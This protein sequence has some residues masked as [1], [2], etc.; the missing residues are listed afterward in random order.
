MANV[1]IETSRAVIAVTRRKQVSQAAW[2][3]ARW[4]VRILLLA[5]IGTI[6]ADLFGIIFNPIILAIAYLALGLGIYLL[7]IDMYLRYRWAGLPD[8]PPLP[9]MLA[10]QPPPNLADYLSEEAADYLL[11]ARVLSGRW[12][13]GHVTAAA[14]FAAAISFPRTGI[15]LQ[16]AG[17][18]L[19]DEQEAELI[20]RLS[21][22]NSAESAQ[23]VTR[24]FELAAESVLTSQ[25][26]RIDEG[27]LLV[28]IFALEPA[29]Q[30]VLFEYHSKQEDLAAVV[31]WMR[32]LRVRYAPRPGYEQPVASGI[33]ED[34][35][36]GY[37]PF[38]S[39]FAS[40][41]TAKAERLGR[42]FSLYSHQDELAQIER[43]LAKG[44]GSNALIIGPPGVGKEAIIL[45]LA[46]RI[47][48]GTSLPSLQFARIL[49]VDPASLLAGAHDKG[50]LEARLLRVFHEAAQAGNVILYLDNIHQLTGGGERLGGVDATELL[51][52]ALQAST[53]RIIATTIPEEYKARI[54]ANPTLASL[55][56]HFNIDEPSPAAT[57]QVLQDIV[58]ETEEATGAF[59]TYPALRAIV[60]VADR[61]LHDQ[62][63]PQK[64]INLLTDIGAYA[65]STQDRLITAETVERVLAE[66]LQLPL[67]AAQGTERE[68]LLNLESEL[69]KTVIAQDEAIGA[70]AAALRRARAGIQ[71]RK[72]PIASLLF[73]GPTGVGK[74]ESAK[75]LARVYF[76]SEQ[77]MLRFD[78]SE[79]QLVDGLV[80]LI[81]APA[82]AQGVKVGGLLADAVH[83]NPFS[84]VLLDELEK[85]HPQVLN[86]FLQV[87][88]DG[89]LTDGTGRL[90]DFTN[91]V[92]IATSNAGAELIRESVATGESQDTRRQKLIDYLQ[93]NGLY[94]PEF[95]NRFDGIIAFHPLNEEQ[96][97]AVTKLMLGE[98]SQRVLAEQEVTIAFSEDLIRAVAQVGFD[99]QFGARPIRRAIQDR[100][101][102]WISNQILAGQLQ[103]GMTVTLTGAQLGFTA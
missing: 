64:A 63:F 46:Q 54:T 88:D 8:L 83:D 52:G 49:A 66:K 29:A 17:L 87:L 76:G 16:R 55:F 27:D 38:L 45:A 30:Q 11:Q 40:D 57:I 72:R 78:M 23:L 41:Y 14:L 58:G 75:A 35:T 18:I 19:N 79:Y 100:V 48:A 47:A 33:A 103:R 69:H 2:L 61:Y 36:A 44:P 71:N 1:H 13:Q 90:V 25:R 67:Q 7:I 39:R 6:T 5:A 26:A 34:W 73:L 21:E 15:L 62:A 77:R 81:G 3:V 97:V 89:R 42:E 85:A 84:L 22:T 68:Q 9:T 74:T 51:M 101:E 92:V 31:E 80:R 65:Q 60:Q 102:T 4:F 91:T 70:I 32:R 86:L 59:F 93:T 94:R 37:T 10:Q 56:E 24:L 12:G 99:P 95:L 28:A 20:R 43:S 50:E 82:S 53:L 96:V 98:L